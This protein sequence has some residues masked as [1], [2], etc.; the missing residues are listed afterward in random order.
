MRGKKRHWELEGG[1]EKKG[2]WEVDGVGE[3]KKGKGWGT[4]HWGLPLLSKL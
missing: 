3:E 4:G 1:R 2:C